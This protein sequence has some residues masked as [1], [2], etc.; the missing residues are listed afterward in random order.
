MEP[1]RILLIEDDEQI[2]TL[3]E[4]R[5]ADAGYDCKS[6][7]SGR[8]GLALLETGIF[9]AALLDIHLGDMTGIEVLEAIK[10]RDPEIDAVLMTGFPEVDTAVQALR[11]GAYD[12]LVKPLDWIALQH[13]LKRIVE[14]RYLQAEVTSLRTRLA[15]ALPV[16]EL[17]GSS[18][19]V[20][21]VKD[22]IAKVAPADTVVLIEGE[23]G[24]GKE[25]IAG[26]IHRL[27]ARAKGPFVPV[28]CSAI[29]GD[30]MESEL[31]GHQKGAFSGATADNRGLFRTADKGTLFLDEVGELPTQLQPKLLRVLQEKE[32]RPVGSTQVH[33]VDVRIIAATNQNLEAAVQSGRFR[34]DLFFRLNVVRIEPPPLRRIKED[35]HALAIH[36]VRKL[37]R[38]FGRQVSSITPDA[39][40]ALM[41]YDFPGNVRELENIMERAYALG[42]NGQISAA[43]LP[44]LVARSKTAGNAA[45]TSSPKTLEDLE[46]DLIAATLSANGNDKARAAQAL[47][48][49]ER[50]LYRRLKKLGL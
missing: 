6:A 50:T 27:S 48:L 32:V 42:A 45:A 30:L 25:L 16:G 22:T 43:D 24:T 39:M 49:S 17:I 46:R 20:K 18:E 7:M 36:F 15:E 47:G 1:L 21:Q 12:Y 35:I 28:N 3:L 34:Q 11:L 33:H 38:K 40:A 19:P 14:R 4:D 2:R 41:N 31:F 37:N 26:A 9:D 13:L 29:P 23:S 8:A 44:A 10:R 5:L